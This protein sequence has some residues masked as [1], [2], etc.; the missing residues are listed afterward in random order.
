[1]NLWPWKSTLKRTSRVVTIETLA[2][3]AN[4]LSCSRRSRRSSPHTYSCTPSR[5]CS[6]IVN[7]RPANR[8]TT[9]THQT[10]TSG[11]NLMSASIQR[12]PFPSAVSNWTRCSSSRTER[13]RRPC[14]WKSRINRM[15]QATLSNRPILPKGAK[16]R[17]RHSPWPRNLINSNQ[18]NSMT[19]KVKKEA[20][21]PS[22]PSHASWPGRVTM[23][24]LRSTQI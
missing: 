19:S 2:K 9:S 4:R 18:W 23:G 11:V 10:I 7:F 15:G 13:R 6:T 22:L 16:L 5:S 8:P 17:N 20:R 3:V 1:M 21:S 14:F 24:E 12:L